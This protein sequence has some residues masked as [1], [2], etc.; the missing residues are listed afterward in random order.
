MPLSNGKLFGS[1]T[2]DDYSITYDFDICAI[3]LSITVDCWNSGYPEV[4][5]SHY[6]PNVF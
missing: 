5:L 2:V 1:S 3:K 6:T 4:G